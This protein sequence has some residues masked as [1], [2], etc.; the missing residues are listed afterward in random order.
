LNQLNKEDD[1]QPLN[2]G[3]KFKGNLGCINA[4]VV[5]NL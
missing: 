5:F 4:Q 2:N 3:D 1:L